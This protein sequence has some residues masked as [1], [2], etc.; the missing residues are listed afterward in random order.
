M[1]PKEK[2]VGKK[3]SEG[4][5]MKKLIALIIMLVVLTGCSKETKLET[6]PWNERQV[7]QMQNEDN[8][9]VKLFE[10]KF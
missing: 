2:E 1:V 6:P 9:S 5:K 10:I 3:E 7:E 8:E 4:K